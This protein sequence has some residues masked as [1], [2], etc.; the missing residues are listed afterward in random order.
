MRFV[1]RRLVAPIALAVAASVCG[2]SSAQ[3]PA[4]PEAAAT[5]FMTAMF[6]GN[7]AE[8]LSCPCAD[9][10]A[11]AYSS[12]EYKELL[13][14][15]DNASQELIVL[16]EAGPLKVEC[17]RISTMGNSVVIRARVFF[18]EKKACSRE[19]GCVQ[20]GKKWKVTSFAR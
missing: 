2:C 6:S 7:K 4:T 19:V 5:C 10:S 14:A 9:Q 16:Q 20:D 3:D 17:E 1:M 12:E 8:L 15:Y 13:E 18:G 11:L